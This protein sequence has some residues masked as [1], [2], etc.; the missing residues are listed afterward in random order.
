VVYWLHEC[1][2]AK[3]LFLSVYSQYLAA[4]KQALKEWNKYQN[5]RRQTATPVT[6]TLLELLE[7]V[8]G[9]EDPFLKFMKALLLYRL[10]RR[11]EAIESVVLSIG[12]YPWNWSAWILLGNCVEDS[13]EVF[14]LPFINFCIS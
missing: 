14:R 1:R 9:S 4:E 11:E 10:S 6:K 3:A 8:K 7:M 13:E 5:S 2:S 12:G